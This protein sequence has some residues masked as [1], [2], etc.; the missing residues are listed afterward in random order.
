M[1]ALA[2][3]IEDF[4]SKPREAARRVLA[5]KPQRL[6][7]A[8]F[9]CGAFALCLWTWFGGPALAWPHLLA[10]TLLLFALETVF[11]CFCAATSHLFME[12]SGEK[13][14]ALALFTALG[15][16]EFVKLL[17]IPIG[18]ILLA[19]EPAFPQ[20]RMAVYAVVCVLQ[21]SAA[22]SL[23]RMAY[24]S[25]LA[26]AWWAVAL[27]FLIIALGLLAAAAFVTASLV[28]GLLSVIS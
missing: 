2:A 1:S 11:A 28:I 10:G 20:A 23:I 15:L 22:A 14:S 7:L 18:L 27:P 19:A 8:G 24:S 26:R 6:A 4:A 16:S 21:F 3:L 12:F 13:G 25:S 9:F 5:E 17:F